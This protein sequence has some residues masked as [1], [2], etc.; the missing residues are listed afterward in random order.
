MLHL[1]ALLRT[2][3]D[4][5]LIFS[6]ESSSSWSQKSIISIPCCG[7]FFAILR[8]KLALSNERVIVLSPIARKS[9]KLA[10]LFYG[11]Q[12]T[13]STAHRLQFRFEK[14]ESSGQ[15][16]LFES[17]TENLLE[18]VVERSNCTIFVCPAWSED[19]LSIFEGYSVFSWRPPRLEIFECPMEP[20]AFNACVHPRLADL[21]GLNLGGKGLASPPTAF[22]ISFV[23]GRQMLQKESSEDQ[24]GRPPLAL[25]VT[26]NDLM[27]RLSKVKEHCVCC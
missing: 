26:F 16:V 1:Q 15:L 21:I 4:A 19:I 24:G 13:D 6:L 3:P 2:D 17:I 10:D 5:G 25:N 12:K 18:I 23:E 7:A 11:Y 8:E 20:R 9:V 22:V 27:R 14:Y